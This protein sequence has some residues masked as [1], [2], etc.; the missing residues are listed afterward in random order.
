MIIKILNRYIKVEYVEFI[1]SDDGEPSGL[2]DFDNNKILIKTGLEKHL[3]LET[4]VHEVFHFIQEAFG[5]KISDK[6]ADAYARG[7]RTVIEDNK[8]LHIFKKVGEKDENIQS[9]Q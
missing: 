8:D 5:L 4:I 6:D 3:E 9:K 7:I 1:Q 2:A